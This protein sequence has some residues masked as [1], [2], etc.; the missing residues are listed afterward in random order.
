[1]VSGILDWTGGTISGDVTIG[2]GGTL[3]VSGADSKDVSS[4]VTLTNAGTINQLA[5]A[6][7]I[8]DGYTS[9]DWYGWAY[10]YP[11]TIN[12]LAGGVYNFQGDGV[13][14]TI[15]PYSGSPNGVINNAGLFRK[16][17]GTGTSVIGTG[18]A[19]NNTGTV[20]VDS[21]TLS[22]SAAFTQAD[23]GTIAVEVAGLG[24]YGRLQLASANLAGAVRL[25]F[26]GGY[27]PDMG[28][29]FNPV[30]Y[31]WRQG[32]GVVTASGDVGLLPEWFSDSLR[33]TVQTVN[34]P[35]TALAISNASVSE[36][37]LAG[38]TIGTLSAIDPDTGDTFTFSLPVGQA[39][40]ASFAISGNQLR[41]A[42]VFNYSA[43]NSYSILVRVTDLGGLSFE[44]VFMMSVTDVPEVPAA[45]SDLAAAAMSQ[46]QITLTWRDNSANETAFTIDR[47]TDPEF[48]QN[49]FT[50]TTAAGTTSYAA[51]GLN[52]N[53][54]Y[55]FRVAAVG[56][57]ANSAYA[58]E[59][60]GMLR[61][62]DANLDAQVDL[63]DLTILAGNWQR[64]G[65]TFAGGDFNGDGAVDLTDLTILAGLW[66]TAAP[67]PLSATATEVAQAN[68]EAEAP[69][70]L[71]SAE[72]TPGSVPPTL[73]AGG[74]FNG[75]GTVDPDPTILA[76]QTQA[77]ALPNPT[78][79][80]AATANL[81]GETHV[82]LLPAENTPASLLL[83]PAAGG[84][85]LAVLEPVTI[86]AGATD[87]W[88]VC[89]LAISDYLEGQGQAD[90]LDADTGSDAILGQAGDDLISSQTAD[91]VIYAADDSI[92]V[93]DTAPLAFRDP[94]YAGAGTD[95]VLWDGYDT[96]QEKE[97]DL[98]A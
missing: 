50:A 2:V 63:T 40:N 57:P 60:H 52:L 37:Q 1:M 13:L 5:G 27:V 14:Q 31:A 20:E 94:V 73:T 48:T 33:V 85:V 71:P 58:M 82:D 24:T 47:A 62:G 90:T 36:N 32:E 30:S 38:T 10:Y 21:G 80:K 46:T 65:M 79:A 78:V 44:K 29:V 41:T 39:D 93:G 75:D 11:T 17:D 89:E 56:S 66:Q 97:I 7:V 23:T 87:D 8:L 69:V 9:Y 45:P 96:I 84:A 26:V 67:A 74:D 55:Y 72:D 83:A 59:V 77:T 53:T 49:L 18:V 6:T 51:A 81:E 25:S 43:K 42:G 54:T 98:L 19:F 28:S 61:L 92:Y 91:D 35:P 22:I 86:A 3:N 68:I 88:I 64:S 76:G 12:N 4:N 34:R 95:S 15:V 70:D 16:S